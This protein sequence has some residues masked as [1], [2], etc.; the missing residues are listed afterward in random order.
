MNNISEAVLA[1]KGARTIE[2]GAAMTGKHVVG[3]LKVLVCW[4]LI[5][6]RTIFVFILVTLQV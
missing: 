5:L 3:Y 6:I 4:I 2:M 1:D